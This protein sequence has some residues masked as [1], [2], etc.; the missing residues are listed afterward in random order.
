M[1]TIGA[2]NTTGQRRPRLKYHPFELASEKEA[3]DHK[4]TRR[5]RTIVRSSR[6]QPTGGEETIEY[7]TPHKSGSEGSTCAAC[8]LPLI[9]RTVRNV[10]ARSHTF[11]FISAVTS[12]RLDVPH[13]CTACH[14]D[15]STERAIDALKKWPSVSPWRVAE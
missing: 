8:H 13:S 5:L 4:L 1:S 6:R 10:N 3:S 15:G 7:H 9:A 14:T 12:E 2:L 11:T